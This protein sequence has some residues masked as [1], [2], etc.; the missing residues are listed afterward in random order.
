MSKIEDLS[1]QLAACWEDAGQSTSGG[2]GM[3]R[4]IAVRNTQAKLA[5]AYVELSETAE[6]HEQARSHLQQARDLYVEILSSAHGKSH[7][8]LVPLLRGILERLGEPMATVFLTV[9]DAILREL[10]MLGRRRYRD[11]N[12]EETAEYLA[13]LL[14]DVPGAQP[15][16]DRVEALR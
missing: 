9:A 14:R 13:S 15:L 5:A 7:R 10:E 12:F 11:A 2:E 4:M 1:R 8:N 6:S 3:S 16:L